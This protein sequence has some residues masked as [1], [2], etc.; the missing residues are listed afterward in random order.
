[1]NVFGLPSAHKTQV[2]FRKVRSVNLSLVQ[3]LLGCGKSHVHVI[4]ATLFL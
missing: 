2:E 3:A 1:M 4:D